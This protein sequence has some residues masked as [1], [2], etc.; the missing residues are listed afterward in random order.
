MTAG[1]LQLGN[2]LLLAGALLFVVSVFNAV[3][4]SRQLRGAAYYAVRQE[5]LSRTRRWAFL[6]T[7]SLLVS[8]GLVIYLSNVPTPTAVA[9]VATPT[10]VVIDVP[11]RMLPTAT[12][13]ASPT[14]HPSKTPKPTSTAMPT[15]LPTGTLPPNIPG[16]LQ[17]P[18]PSAVPASPNAKLAFTTLASIVDNKGTPSDPGLAFPVGTR[19][20]RLFFQAANVNNGA[21][22]SVLCY[23]G[24]ALVDTYI[25]LWKWGPRAQTARAFCGIDGSPGTYNV[26]AYLGP[27]KQFDVSFQ[28]LPAT[29]TPHPPATP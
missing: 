25:D 24:N 3:R 14:R 19:S 27:I 8:G 6:A 1:F 20:V 10:A 22:W 9:D 4:A 21:M 23:K 28:I 7:I 16:I 2:W 26:S 5:A 17:T 11:S 18:V 12:F 13:T 29:P 15:L